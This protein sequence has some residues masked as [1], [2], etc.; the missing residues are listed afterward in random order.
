MLVRSRPGKKVWRSGKLLGVRCEMAGFEEKQHESLT[1]ATL[2][3]TVLISKIYNL[4][5]GLLGGIK[6]GSVTNVVPEVEVNVTKVGEHEGLE[7]LAIDMVVHIAMENEVRKG[8]LD[9]QQ[10][11]LIL[12]VSDR[13]STDVRVL[14]SNGTHPSVLDMLVE[15]IPEGN[16]RLGECF[17]SGTKICERRV[18]QLRNEV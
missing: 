2:R 14:P 15:F 18:E 1:L 12:V 5:V 8:L 3:R 13:P 17:G 4:R 6:E 16:A 7:L 9:L 10:G 11:G